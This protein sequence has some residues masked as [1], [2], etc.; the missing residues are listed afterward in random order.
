MARVILNPVAIRATAAEGGLK[1]MRPMLRQ[2]VAIAKRLAPKGRNYSPSGP[3]TGGDLRASLGADIP[4]VT[5][6]EIRSRVG[7]RKKYAASVSGGARPHVIRAKRAKVLAFFW[8]VKG[9]TVFFP[10]VH[11]PGQKANKYLQRSIRLAALANG[12][13]VRFL[14]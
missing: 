14:K 10:Q 11:H 9:Q 5:P 3:G 13:K 12:F 6:G 1:K 2:S 4:R 7:S 8:N